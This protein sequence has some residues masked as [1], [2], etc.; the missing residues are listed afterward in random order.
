[1]VQL[2]KVVEKCS[3][4]RSVLEIFSDIAGCKWSLAVLKAIDSGYRRPG[5]LQKCIRGIST[6]VLNQR[7]AK[8]CRYH[9][10]T[11][12][13]YPVI[14]PKVEYRLSSS[15]EKFIGLLRRI[16]KFRLS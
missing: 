5:V 9:L 3:P 7:L 6:K 11:K 4:P 16:E 15:G 1:M 8:L 12:T 2:M 13:V 10:V 14:P